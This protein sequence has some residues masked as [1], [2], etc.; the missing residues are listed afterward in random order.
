[1]AST[2]FS[3]P[4]ALSTIRCSL[5]PS[6]CLSELFYW[7]SGIAHGS[8]IFLTTFF[9]N[10]LALEVTGHVMLVKVGTVLLRFKG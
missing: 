4:P 6:S 5:F 7:L 3:V 9:L 1:M 10:D 2:Q 8:C